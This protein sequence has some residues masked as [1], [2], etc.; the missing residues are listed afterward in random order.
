LLIA[1]LTILTSCNKENQ[2]LDSDFSEKSSKNINGNLFQNLR[3]ESLLK[4]GYSIDKKFSTDRVVCYKLNDTLVFINMQYKLS[5][6]PNVN[7]KSLYST[8]S[9]TMYKEVSIMSCAMAPEAP[10]HID[11]NYDHG[12][13]DVCFNMRGPD[14]SVCTMIGPSIVSGDPQDSNNLWCMSSGPSVQIIVEGNAIE[15]LDNAADQDPVESFK[16]N[17]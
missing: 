16:K 9:Y 11:D 12:L 2:Y 7:S 5:D 1:L 10:R 8:A 14:M 6:K 15:L 4:S 13:E 17:P 3:G